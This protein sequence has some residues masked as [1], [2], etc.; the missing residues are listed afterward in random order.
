MQ[1]QRNSEASPRRTRVAKHPGVYYRETSSGRRYEITFLDS[2][3]RAYVFTFDAVDDHVFSGGETAQA[4]PQVMVAAAACLRMLRQQPKTI[5]D[6]INQ[7][8]RDFDAAARA[9]HVK[10][11]V[12]KFGFRLR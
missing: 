10:P 2:G 8:V 5:G 11:D 1:E 7:A 3:V 4:W 12:V 6:G 9:G